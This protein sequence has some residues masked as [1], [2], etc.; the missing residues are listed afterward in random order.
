MLTV[1]SLVP[2]ILIYQNMQLNKKQAPDTKQPK[3]ESLTIRLWM[4]TGSL[5]IFGFFQELPGEA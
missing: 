3:F 1:N 4:N 5:I 2:K